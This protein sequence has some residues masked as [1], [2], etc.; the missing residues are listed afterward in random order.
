LGAPEVTDNVARVRLRNPSDHAISYNAATSAEWAEVSPRTGRIAAHDTALLVVRALDAAPEGDAR[1]TLTVT[2][3]AGGAMTH[4]IAWTLEHP[5]DL[6]ATAQ[7]CAV[8]VHV[9][10]EG[11]LASLVLH[12]RDTTEHAVDITSGPDGYKAQLAPGGQP[13]TY[14]V[15]AVDARGNQSRTADQVIEANA[16]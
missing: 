14:W 7:G 4:E 15:T 10:E 11:D 1:A 2:T 16:C 5:P 3:S 6:D 13:I 9:V 8:D 12:W